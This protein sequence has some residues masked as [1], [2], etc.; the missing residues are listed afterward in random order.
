MAIL[1]DCP[2][3][4]ERLARGASVDYHPP[5]A[6]PCPQPAIVPSQDRERLAAWSVNDVT[7]DGLP[8]TPSWCGPTWRGYFTVEDA[9]RDYGVALTGE[10]PAVDLE[11][12]DRLRRDR[13]LAAA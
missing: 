13:R 2:S 3:P 9:E 5:E 6:R 11:A 7:R 12:I 1:L 10:P 4:R 8:A